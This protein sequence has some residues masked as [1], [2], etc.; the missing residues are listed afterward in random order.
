MTD[1]LIIHSD[2][3]AKYL[4]NRSEFAFFSWFLSHNYWKTE[5]GISIK[6]LVS[7]VSVFWNNKWIIKE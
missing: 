6:V 3:R 4:P 5:T 2:A 1:N 7:E